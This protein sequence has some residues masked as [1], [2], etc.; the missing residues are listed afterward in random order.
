M[1]VSVVDFIS[2]LSSVFFEGLSGTAVPSCAQEAETDEEIKVN[3]KE[4]P[5]CGGKAYL[6]VEKVCFGHGE[7][8]TECTVR[9]RNCH[10]RGP[11]FD[12]WE[13][14]LEECKSRAGDA[15][16]DRK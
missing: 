9:C 10:A 11:N 3:Y 6:E 13:Y 14:P 1:T 15:W 8:A 5:F 4:C 16:N 7:Y 12:T 2:E